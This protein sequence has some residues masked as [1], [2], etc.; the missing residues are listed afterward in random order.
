MTWQITDESVLERGYQAKQGKRIYAAAIQPID[1][2]Q[3]ID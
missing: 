3:K 2:L 1:L